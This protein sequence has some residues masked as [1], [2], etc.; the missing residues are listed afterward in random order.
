MT[1]ITQYVVAFLCLVGN[2][3]AQ[4]QS[5]LPE[6]PADIPKDAVLRMVLT[7]KAPSGQDAIWQS[8][9]GTIHEFF[10]FND[11]GRGPKIYTTYRLDANG[12]ITSEESTGVDYM[13]HTIEE[14]F[15]LVEGKA[16]W[17]NQSEDVQLANANGKFYIDLDGGPESGA[18][19]ARAL[20]IPGNNGKLAVLPSGAAN[21]R[22]LQ[23]VLVEAG[24]KKQT[25]TLYEIGGLAF[26]PNYL[27]LDEQQQLIASVSGWFS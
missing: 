8:K 26:T 23:S 12:L 7:D 11:R 27:W 16:A 6:L 24:G 3:N 25:A 1:R 20:L 18:I 21:V 4:Q 5:P 2:L 13:K 9:D 15:S 19:L 14:H 17:K 22:K 10:Q